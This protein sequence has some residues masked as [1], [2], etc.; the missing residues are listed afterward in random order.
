MKFGVYSYSMYENAD[1]ARYEARMLYN[2]A[3]K[4]EFYINDYEQQT[5]TS[6]DANTATV[7][8]ADQMK[9]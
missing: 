2:R 5:V 9:N 4:A 8:W 7:A 3:P 1:D 6:G